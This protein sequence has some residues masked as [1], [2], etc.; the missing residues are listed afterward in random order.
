MSQFPSLPEIAHLKD[1]FVRFPKNSRLLMQ[2]TNNVLRSE[3]HL[4]VAQRELIAAYVSGLNACT[5][6]RG[7]HE[8]YARAFGIAEGVVQE[9]LDDLETANVD[10]KLRPILEYVKK[11]SVLPPKLTSQDAQKVWDAGWDED[12]LFEAIEVAGLFNMM[13]RIIEGSGVNFDYDTDPGRH[14]ISG[15]TPDA[16]ANSYNDFADSIAQ[17]VEVDR[18]SRG[19][20]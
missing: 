19:K 3:G 12:A 20:R 14:T 6:C 8:I 11:L 15:G 16:M 2:F 10:P 4:S 7:S 5:F 18:A 9:L 13:N 17:Q 1:V